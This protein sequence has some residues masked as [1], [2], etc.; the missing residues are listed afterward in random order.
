MS[1]T[2]K[3]AQLEKQRDKLGEQ[4]RVLQ[5]QQ[6]NKELAGYVGKYFKFRNCYSCPQN[7]ADYW[8][9][10]L[11]VNGIDEECY[12]V[13]T[14]FEITADKKIHVSFEEHHAGLSGYQEIKR[15]EFAAAYSV[16]EDSINFIW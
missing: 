5:R 13:C 6:R 14:A 1:G 12:L 7:E 9:R 16:L 2:T 4:I 15:S 11:Y 3:L 10:Y 8:W